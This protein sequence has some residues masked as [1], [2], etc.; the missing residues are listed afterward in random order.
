MRII[1]T[2]QDV[3]R[4]ID[5]G[6]VSEYALRYAITELD[7]RSEMERSERWRDATDDEVTRI[8]RAMMKYHDDGEVI[9]M[10]CREMLGGDGN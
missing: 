10:F 6:Q 4:L 3:F 9:A 5:S 1:S 2:E 8:V 7:V